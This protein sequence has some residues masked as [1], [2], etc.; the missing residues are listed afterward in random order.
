MFGFVNYSVMDESSRCPVFENEKKGR[1]KN[2]EAVEF[3]Y[4]SPDQ[5]R[6]RRCHLIGRRTAI[7]GCSFYKKD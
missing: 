7:F 1:N 5:K 4:G 2:R 3:N 6:Q